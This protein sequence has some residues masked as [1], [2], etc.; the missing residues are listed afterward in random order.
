MEDQLL[1]LDPRAA[2]AVK[3][4]M[5]IDRDYFIAVPEDP[6]PERLAGI[7]QELTALLRG[8]EPADSPGSP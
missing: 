8:D 6:S 4:L 3:R 2:G 5:D 7:R 1:D